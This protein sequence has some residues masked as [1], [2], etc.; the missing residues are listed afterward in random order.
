MTAREVDCDLSND[1]PFDPALH[2]RKNKKF[3][4]KG[5]LFEV[6]TAPEYILKIP[7]PA[8]DLPIADFLR[9]SFPKNSSALVFSKAESWFSTDTPTT[10]V[11]CLLSRPI[12]PLQFLEDLSKAVGQAWF[13]GCTSIVDP[14]YNDGRDRLPLWSLT[15]WQEWARVVKDQNMWRRSRDWTDKELKKP[16]LDREDHDALLTARSLL[17]M[18]GWD[19][20]IHGQWTTF[21][22]S[23]IL[24]LE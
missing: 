13:D 6:H 2:I 5:T 14:R 24:S 1:P 22:L 12:P 23:I 21:N 8:P 3:P 7:I 18:L 19:T 17:D 16:D 15:L 4:P 11:D 9:L 10:A 20:K